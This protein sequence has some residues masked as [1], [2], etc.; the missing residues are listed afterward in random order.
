MHLGENKKYVKIAVTGIAIAAGTIAILFFFYRFSA[1]S[2]I[3]SR[4][5]SILRPFLYG[6]AIAYILSP[7]CGRLEAFFEKKL[8]ECTGMELRILSSINSLNAGQYTDDMNEILIM[9]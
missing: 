2:A 3:L 9:F 4:L 6:G 7:L 8:N 1:V 5:F